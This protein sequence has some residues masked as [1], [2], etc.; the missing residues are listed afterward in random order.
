MTIA[1]TDRGFDAFRRESTMVVLT[2]NGLQTK[3]GAASSIYLLAFALCRLVQ[4]DLGQITSLVI[5]P[6]PYGDQ[7]SVI[8][9]GTQ[10]GTSST[11][12]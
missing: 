5:V 10:N 4:I 12:C 11:A 7:R 1:S 2:P 6:T 9:R 3:G 8:G